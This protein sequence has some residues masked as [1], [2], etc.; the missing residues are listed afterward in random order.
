MNLPKKRS[1]ILLIYT[2]FLLFLISCGG[3]YNIYITN[4]I[5]NDA[6]IIN[7]L[8]TIRGSLQRV[9]KLEINGEKSDEI[10]NKIDLTLAEFETEKIKLFDEKDDVMNAI[11]SVDNSW[12]KVKTD[13]YNFRKA[14]SE[15][16]RLQLLKDSEDA[17]HKT[18]NMVFVSQVSAEYKVSKYRLSVIVFFF[19]FLLS[20]IVIFL[21]KRYV[22]DAL[23][24]MVNNDS[25]TGIHN[26]RYFS[27]FLSNEI[28]RSE[29]YK[30]TFS[31]IMLDID[32]FKKINDNYGHDIGDKILQQLV[33]TVNLSVRRSDLFARIGGEEFAV[34]APETSLENAIILAEKIRLNVEQNAFIKDLKITISL[35]ISQYNDK[36]DTNTI[37][38]RA[39]NALYRAKG[40]GR[41]RSEIE[42]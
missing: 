39:D 19:N 28:T 30:K 8:G 40:N 38:K 3:A 10:I 22:K 27:E 9:T 37:F 41:N 36:D 34:V 42:L 32:F 12:G 29:R 1:S 23:E 24:E 13:I 16:H 4:S 21:I 35:G 7:K 5:S 14:S 6:M 33:E 11:K 17:W 31:L 18:N 20:V 26:R 15:E 2:V 25:L